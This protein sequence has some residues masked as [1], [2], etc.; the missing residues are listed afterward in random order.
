M[1]DSNGLCVEVRPTGAKVWRYPYRFAGKASMVT[2]GEYP[3]M[4]L[5]KARSERERLKE[6]LLPRAPKGRT[7]IWG[8][9]LFE[10]NHC[11]GINVELEDAREEYRGHAHL[12]FLYISQQDEPL[13]GP[14]LLAQS[15]PSPL[16]FQSPI[17][18]TGQ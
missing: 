8:L 11:D 17:Q 16:R 3:A 5:Q 4:S 10:A 6:R 9:G 18:N 1:A 7:P 12:V 15:E 13:D 14:N 2:I